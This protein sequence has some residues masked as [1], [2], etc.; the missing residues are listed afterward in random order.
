MAYGK[1]VYLLRPDEILS[2]C[3]T[4]D[5]RQTPDQLCTAIAAQRTTDPGHCASIQA[6][7]VQR[8]PAKESCYGEAFAE[9]LKSCD[10]EITLGFFQ[11]CFVQQIDEANALSCVE[12]TGQQLLPPTCLLIISEHCP[13]MVQE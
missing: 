6:D 2:L 4:L 13:E 9:A 7:C 11:R 3:E 5:K 12:P 1:P 10:E 8:W